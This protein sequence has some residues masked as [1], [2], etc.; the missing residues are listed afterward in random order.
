MNFAFWR[1]RKKITQDLKAVTE[2]A[3]DQLSPGV[4]TFAIVLGGLAVAGVAAYVV[5]QKR[6]KKRSDDQASAAKP[7]GRATK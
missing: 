6:Q 2:V 1:R 5:H 7:S 3:G 4:G